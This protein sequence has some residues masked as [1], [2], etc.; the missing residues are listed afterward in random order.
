MYPIHMSPIK[1][2]LCHLAWHFLY[3]LSLLAK[4]RVSAQYTW[5]KQSMWV[6]KEQRLLSC[7]HDEHKLGNKKVLNLSRV[8]SKIYSYAKDSMLKRDALTSG[9]GYYCTINA[10]YL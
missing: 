4:I 8:S 3:V 2:C 6:L 10:V 5:T 1:S 9:I 7:Y